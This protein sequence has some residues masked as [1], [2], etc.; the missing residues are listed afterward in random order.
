MFVPRDIDTEEKLKTWLMTWLPLMTDQDITKLLLHYPVDTNVTA[1]YATNGVELPDA[2]SV[3]PVARD[4]QA[5]AD[6]IYGE[7]TFVCPSYWLSEAYAGS[8][9]TSYRYQYSIIPALHGNDVVGYFGPPSDVQSPAFVKAFMNIYGNFVTKDNPSISAALVYGGDT[10]DHAK[11][12]A[13]EN[14]PEYSASTPYQINLNQT[15]GT[16][17]MMEY[18]GANVTVLTGP[19][20]KNDFSKVNA[21]TW[22]GGRGRRCDYWR[23]ISNLLPN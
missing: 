1:D 7:L 17:S 11:P 12:N 18:L 9:R 13:A 16:P 2:D 15:G 14:W 5:R 22:E 20:L 19:T 23:S 21:Y 6:N 4:Q 10:N 3:S 8:G